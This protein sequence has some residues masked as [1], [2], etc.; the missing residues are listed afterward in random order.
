MKTHRRFA[1]NTVLSLFPAA[2]CSAS[3]DQRPNILYIMADDHA[4][5]AISCYGEML[6]NIAP[7]PNIDRIANEGARFDRVFCSNAICGPSRAAILT[8]KYSHLNGYFKNESGGS[9]DSSQETFPK[10]LHSAGYQTAVFGKWHLGSAPTG[11]DYSKV[12]LNNSG[13]GSYFDPVFLINGTERVTEHPVHSTRQIAHDAIEWLKTGRDSEKPF[14]LLYQF[15][16]PHRPWDPD[17]AY[18]NLFAN[19]EIPEPPTFDDSYEGRA[20]A[21]DQWMSIEHNINRRDCKLTPPADL[22]GKERIA[23]L[24]AGNRNEFWTPDPSLTGEALKKWKYQRYI[25][26]YLRCVH[27]VDV[28]VGQMLDYLDQAGLADNTIVV[29]TSDQGFY[30]GEHGWFDKRFMYEQSFRMP[31]LMRWPGYIRPGTVNKDLL[32]NI[33]FAPTLLDAAGVSI[34]SDMQG[35]SFAFGSPD[36]KAV[37]YHYYEF[38]FWHHVQPHYGIR[39]DRYKLIHFYY[40]MDQWELFDLQND[41]YELHNLIDNPEYAGLINDLK[42]ELE[43]QQKQYGDTMSLDRMREMTDAKI[44]HGQVSKARPV[45]K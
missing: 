10:L 26:D 32:M 28:A 39:T 15:K 13:Q 37:Y 36:R 19:V 30:L 5:Q 22:K 42:N 1:M 34:P 25:K 29:Y 16:A 27:G 23:W 43:Q 12:F 4:W 38:P 21:A 7:T 40:S 18:S 6:S 8:G 17:P 41:P 11:F 44:P 14:L 45:D 24:T 31:F 3:A 33:D 9:F 2:I 35:K 20:A